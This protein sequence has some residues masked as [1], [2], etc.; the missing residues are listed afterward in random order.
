MAVMPMFPLGHPLLPGS[1]LPLHVFEER[2][3]QMVRDILADDVDPPEFGV[4]MIERGTEVGGGD[5]RSSVGT[6]ARIDDIQVT[7]DGRYGLIAIGT[8]RVR[9]NAWLPDD[10]YPLADVDDWP[11]EGRSSVGTDALAARHERVRE[12]HASARELGDPV[13]DDTAISDEPGLAAFHLAALAPLGAADRQRILAAPGLDERLVVLD[14]ALD[15]AM[16]V[17]DFRRS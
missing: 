6:V 8:R 12:I 14:A 10:P 7:E 13:P 2:Y 16:A 9:V 11:D 15:D 1:V 3:R 5:V 4:V 17:L